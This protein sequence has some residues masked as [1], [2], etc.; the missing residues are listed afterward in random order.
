MVIM[1]KILI[2]SNDEK[3]RE[4]TKEI[5]C[6]EYDLILCEDANQCPEFVKNTKIRNLII[7]IDGQDETF[8]VIAEVKSQNAKI[9]IT[10]LLGSKKEKDAKE[11]IN[12]RAVCYIL[13]TIKADELLKSCQ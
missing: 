7:D 9:K 12:A 5:L 1:S 6:D 8:D 4:S 13:K 3:V 11:A 2:C 10:A